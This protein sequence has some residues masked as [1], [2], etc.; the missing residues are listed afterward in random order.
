M[1]DN[2]SF[3]ASEILLQQ[4]FGG[5][6]IKNGGLPLLQLIDD[7]LLAELSGFLHHRAAQ[8]LKQRDE[9]QGQRLQL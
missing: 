2:N 1:V 3:P 8:V 7:V 6:L 5:G 9:G 4:L